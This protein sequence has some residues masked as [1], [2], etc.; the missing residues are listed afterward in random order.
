MRGREVKHDKYSEWDGKEQKTTLSNTIC[1]IVVMRLHALLAGQ[2]WFSIY[3][4]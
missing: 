3:L 1:T 4:S 2:V